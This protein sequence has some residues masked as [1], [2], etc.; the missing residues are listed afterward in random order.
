MFE[1]S[2]N[3]NIFD[4]NVINILIL[5]SGII[6]LGS[7]YISKEMANWEANV[8]KSIS[9][10]EEQLQSASN[11]LMISQYQ[12]SITPMIFDFM[13]SES[14]QINKKLKND[15]FDIT[16]IELVRYIN[17]NQLQFYNSKIRISQEII[18]SILALLMLQIMIQ[19]EKTTKLSSLQNQTINTNILKL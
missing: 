17:T 7:S 19:L 3:T 5:L 15:I 16:A 2:L 9:E 8:L 6:Y 14:N 12:F 11:R 18:D 4:S 1:I 13:F 10:S